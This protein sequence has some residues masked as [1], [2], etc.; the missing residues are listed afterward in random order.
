MRGDFKR[1]SA[2]PEQRD[3]E[4]ERVSPTPWQGE[5]LLLTLKREEIA[6]LQMQVAG[7]ETR[8]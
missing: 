1:D 7:K 6:S 3:P 5:A 2:L 8:T 4:C